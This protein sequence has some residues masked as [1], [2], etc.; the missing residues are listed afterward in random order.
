M[1]REGHD[2]VEVLCITFQYTISVLCNVRVARVEA[3]WCA[4]FVAEMA[5][6]TLSPE[7]AEM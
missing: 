7:V 3:V 1:S 6:L 5:V 2:S 4:L